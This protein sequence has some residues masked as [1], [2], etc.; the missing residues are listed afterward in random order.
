LPGALI[1]I[2]LVEGFRPY[3][4]L[5]ASL[6]SKNLEA[7]VCEA[8][9]GQEAVMQAQRFKPDLVLLNIGLPK[10]NGLEAARQIGTLVPSSRIIFLTQETDID[11]VKEAFNL[12]AWGYVLKQDA[13]TELLAAI[14]E[15]LGGK[16]FVSSGLSNE[17]LEA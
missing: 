8:D 11:V 7:N 6:L 5:V 4:S 14:A 9:D 17:G 3:R 2:L 13:E 12:G 1:R 10:L 15:V 16:H